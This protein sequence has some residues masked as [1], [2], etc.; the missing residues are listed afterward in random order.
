MCVVC[1]FSKC[2]QK[3]YQKIYKRCLVEN[4]T[5]QDPI[6]NLF[7]QKIKEYPKLNITLNNAKENI[8][9]KTIFEE[10]TRRLKAI[11]SKYDMNTIEK[12]PK[13]NFNY[14]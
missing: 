11:Q 3:N 13:F 10:Y 5:I 4:K 12:L 6:K 9:L 8:E 1:G 7:I 2:L 14:K